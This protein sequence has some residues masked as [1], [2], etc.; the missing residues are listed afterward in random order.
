MVM[1]LL[2]LMYIPLY[3]GVYRKLARLRKLINV[4]R[5]EILECLWIINRLSKTGE[6]E[7]VGLSCLTPIT[8]R[9]FLFK[10][11]FPPYFYIYVKIEKSQ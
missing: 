3:T 10:V 4:H 7:T 2:K 6:R 1:L 9:G 11:Y 5:T 8:Y